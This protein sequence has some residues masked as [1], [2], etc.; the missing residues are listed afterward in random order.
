MKKMGRTGLTGRLKQYQAV[1]QKYPE[2]V[3]F[4]HNGDFYEI[5][6]E[7]AKRAAPILHVAL[8]SV[9]MQKGRDIPK[10]NVPFDDV[11]IYIARLLTAGIKV[12]I[13]NP[14]EDPATAKGLATQETAQAATPNLVL[15]PKA[16]NP[17]PAFNRADAVKLK[18]KPD[19]LVAAPWMRLPWTLAALPGQS[20]SRPEPVK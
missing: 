14:V 12:A 19:S 8:T 17:R 13:C 3:L 4:F 5:F 10:C 20:D 18:E 1:K 15:L 2:D 16:Q 11:D 6:F 7:D 9:S